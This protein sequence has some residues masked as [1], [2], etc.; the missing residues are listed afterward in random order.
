MYY[1]LL[2][3]SRIIVIDD[4]DEGLISFLDF[5]YAFQLQLCF[6]GKRSQET[7]LCFGIK[8]VERLASLDLV[9]YFKQNF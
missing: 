1:L 4:I 9:L 5:L 7:R 2:K 6:E 8:G 3:C